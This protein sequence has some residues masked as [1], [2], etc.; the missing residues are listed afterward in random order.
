M[1]K[2]HIICVCPAAAKVPIEER[3]YLRDQR[4]KTGPKGAFQM[5]SVDISAV[6]RDRRANLREQHV[7]SQEDIE[8]AGPSTQPTYIPEQSN[9]E[10]RVFFFAS[11]YMN[12][13]IITLY[14][15]L[16]FRI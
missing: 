3:A 9:S 1:H 2:K 16:V 5:S 11:V 12:Y 4:S 6:K 15:M 8:L 13:L 14:A 7:F 10:V